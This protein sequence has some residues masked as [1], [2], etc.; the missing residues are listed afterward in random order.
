M[1][2]PLGNVRG[3]NTWGCSDQS[4]PN[5]RSPLG[6]TASIRPSL[7]SEVVVEDTMY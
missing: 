4:S 1:Y 5:F 7:L 3:S 2:Y 6:V